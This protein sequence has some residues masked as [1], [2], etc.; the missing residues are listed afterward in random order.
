MVNNFLERH[1]NEQAMTKADIDIVRSTKF[2]GREPPKYSKNLF[3]DDKSGRNV[4]AGSTRN[5]V[6][7]YQKRRSLYSLQSLQ[8]IGIAIPCW[9][10]QLGVLNT[11]AYGHPEMIGEETCTTIQLR[12]AETRFM[13]PARQE[14]HG[15][16]WLRL[17]SLA[18]TY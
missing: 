14:N 5:K 6:F 15:W 11:V 4:F 10:H 17:D 1:M 7:I 8:I 2:L 13:T 16:D 18:H 3:V 12:S 9:S